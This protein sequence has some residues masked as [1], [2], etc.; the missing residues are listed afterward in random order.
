MVL[1]NHSP[2]LVAAQLG[3]ND[4]GVLALRTYIDNGGVESTDCVDDA[5]LPRADARSS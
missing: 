4:G 3:H 2:D 1:N 5:L